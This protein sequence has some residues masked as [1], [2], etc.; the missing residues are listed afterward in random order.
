MTT[1]KNGSGKYRCMILFDND[2]SP[3]ILI[4]LLNIYSLIILLWL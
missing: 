2:V 3:F 1:N 4:P